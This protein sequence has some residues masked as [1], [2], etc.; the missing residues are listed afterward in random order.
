MKFSA[1]IIAIV[2]AVS[3]VSLRSQANPSSS[4]ITTNVAL[5]GVSGEA[6]KQDLDFIG[7]ALVASYN[8]VHWEAGHFLTGEHSTEFVGQLCKYCPDDD[9]AASDFVFA[10]KAPVGQLCKYC[11]DDDAAMGTSLLTT[12]LVEDCAG[13]CNKEA[14]AEL[15]VSFCNKIRNSNSAYLKSANACSLEFDIEGKNK[16]HTI[17]AADAMATMDSTLILKGVAGDATTKEELALIAKAYVSA[18]N[19]VHWESGHYMSDAEIP[20]SAGTPVGQLCKYCPDDDSFGGAT[21]LVLDIV[22]PIV[23]QLCKYCPDD[24]ASTAQ[25]TDLKSTDL[26]RKAVEVAF[27]KKIQASVSDKLRATQSCSV[28]ME[29]ILAADAKQTMA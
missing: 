20:F 27:C 24:D 10:V 19:D 12:A 13:L 26:T 25:L 23:G 4:T 8:D 21:T 9:S 3:A 6:S 14:V 7:K 22:T 18:Y 5:K 1:A 29:S 15:E 11:P 28:A 16:K 17:P 2:P